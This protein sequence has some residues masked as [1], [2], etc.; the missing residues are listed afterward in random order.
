MDKKLYRSNVD[1]KIAGVCGGLGEYFNID[2][3]IVRIIAIILVF[4]HGAGLIAYIIAWIVMPKR[5]LGVEPEPAS[6]ATR[7]GSSIGKFLPGIVLVV[8]GLIFLLENIYWWFDF[9]DF[10]WPA[11]LIVAGLALVISSVNKK[12]QPLESGSHIQEVK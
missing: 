6:P 5:P 12:E 10:I 9:W 1:S 4:A 8:I 11:L 2:P 7:H 3:T